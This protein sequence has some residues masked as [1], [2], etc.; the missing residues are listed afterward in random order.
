M[1]IKIQNTKKTY[2]GGGGSLKKKFIMYPGFT[3][4]ADL[5]V[6]A[7]MPTAAQ[8]KKTYIVL[9]CLV[10]ANAPDSM[11]VSSDIRDSVL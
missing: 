11:A 6:Q 7:S 9:R 8:K 5:I 4:E 2:W 10:P 1:K 3:F